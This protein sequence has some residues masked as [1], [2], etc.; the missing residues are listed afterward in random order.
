MDLCYQVGLGCCVGLQ[1]LYPGS[2]RQRFVSCRSTLGARW[3]IFRLH[4]RQQLVM[5]AGRMG[6]LF[7]EFASGVD[8]SHTPPTPQDEDSVEVLAFVL[9]HPLCL[10]RQVD[11]RPF[12][13]FFQWVRPTSLPI[14]CQMQ[15]CLVAANCKV[16]LG[17][18]G[19]VLLLQ[20]LFI[21]FSVHQSYMA[22]LR[23]EHTGLAGNLLLPVACAWW[24]V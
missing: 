5:H 15:H 18:A 10:L 19:L 21:S 13:A 17:Q 6:E 12:K 8:V 20:T 9:A 11:L 23:T 22:S 16:R 7:V 24:D 3:C 2:Y 1:W 14:I 4:S